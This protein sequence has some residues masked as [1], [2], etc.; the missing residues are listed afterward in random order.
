MGKN[1]LELTA[2]GTRCRVKLLLGSADRH[3]TQA[4]RS[5]ALPPP[6]LQPPLKLSILADPQ[7]CW[8]SRNEV[9]RAPSPVLQSREGW[10]WSRDTPAP[11]ISTARTQSRGVPEAPV[12]S[13]NPQIVIKFLCRSAR[14]DA[15][16]WAQ[17][18]EQARQS[19]CFLGACQPGAGRQVIK[20]NINDAAA[21]GCA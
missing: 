14:H 5:K 12:G 16:S 4:G 18:R 7:S 6:A 21:S 1:K 13:F 8:Q 3:G 2:V 10:V 9:C 20:T 11:L 17:G 19:T 15:R